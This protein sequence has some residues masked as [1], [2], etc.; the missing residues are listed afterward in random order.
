EPVDQVELLVDRGD[1]GLD[2]R[3]GPGEPHRL[4]AEHDGA[5]VGPMRP[6][7]DL[8]ERGL[9]GAVLA[10][11]AVHLP[12][13]HLEIHPV[14]GPDPGELLDDPPHHQQLAHRYA[15]LRAVIRGPVVDGEAEKTWSVMSRAPPITPARSPSSERTIGRLPVAS[16]S[17][18]R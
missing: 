15:P 4:A 6:G 14:E 13:P 17:D 1:P 16:G 5:R 11:E 3:G 8:D 9:A 12:R 10:E 7:Q 2:R 18:L